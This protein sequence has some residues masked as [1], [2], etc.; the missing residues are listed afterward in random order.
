MLC[1]IKYP[2]RINVNLF[3]SQVLAEET[4]EIQQGRGTIFSEKGRYNTDQLVAI[5]ESNGHIGI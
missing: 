1:G 2:F 3:F 5:Q 4:V